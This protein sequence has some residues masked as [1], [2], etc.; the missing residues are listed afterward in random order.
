MLNRRQKER[1]YS[2]IR[3]FLDACEIWG[4]IFNNEELLAQVRDIEEILQHLDL[5]DCTDATVSEIEN[6]T[7]NLIDNM[8]QVLKSFGAQGLVFRGPK[9]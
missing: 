8:D 7:L 6:A 2:S 5:N 4:K 3:L 9:H 1:V